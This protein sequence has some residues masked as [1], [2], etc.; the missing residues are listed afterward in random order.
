M[1]Q[2]QQ[3]HSNDNKESWSKVII[4]GLRIGLSWSAILILI[5]I[6]TIRL[7]HT[8]HELFR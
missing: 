2:E 7:F 1:T 5:W 6:V 8:V 4:D 3:T